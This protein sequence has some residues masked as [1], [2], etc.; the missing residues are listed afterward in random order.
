MNDYEQFKDRHKGETCILIANGPG[1]DNIPVE[2]LKKYPSFGVNRITQMLPE[3]APTYY[4]CIGLNQ[5]DTADKRATIYPVIE[6]MDLR[7]AFINRLAIQ[8]FRH[9]KVWSILSGGPYGQKVEERRAFSLSP[10]EIV[11]IG[12]TQLY[13]SMQIANYMGFKTMLIVGMDHEYPKGPKK[14]FYRDDEVP[15]FESAPGPRYNDDSDTWRQVA[16]MILKNA[17]LALDSLGVE[18]VNLSNPTKCTLFTRGR[19]E[20][21]Q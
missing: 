4:S 3:F 16:D 2:F 20:E 21:W 11:G 18:V 19:I 12:A 5:L 1:L 17:K 7:A 14:H 13:M 9:P 15:L 10:L 8:Y 6:H